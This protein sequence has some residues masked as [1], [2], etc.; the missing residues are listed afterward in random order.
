MVVNIK[1]NENI[2]KM[3]AADRNINFLINDQK[4]LAD[5]FEFELNNK[6]KIKTLK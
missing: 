3:K 2:F 1:G 6:P 5:E 4:V